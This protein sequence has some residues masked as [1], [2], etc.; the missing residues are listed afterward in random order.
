[1]SYF[2]KPATDIFIPDGNGF[3]QAPPEMSDLSINEIF[4]F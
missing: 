4:T 3:R 1:M 2:N